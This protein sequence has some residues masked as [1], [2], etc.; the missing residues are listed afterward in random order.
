MVFEHVAE[1]VGA[2]QE[3]V[4]GHLVDRLGPELG[5]DLRRHAQGASDAVGVGVVGGLL[6]REQAPVDQLLHD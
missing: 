4:A 1:A 6:Q 3:R 5:L 2:Q